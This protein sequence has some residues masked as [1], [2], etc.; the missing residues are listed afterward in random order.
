MMSS[1]EWIRTLEAEAGYSGGELKDVFGSD[2]IYFLGYRTAD[3]E[4]T[5]LH[6][7][8]ESGEVNQVDLEHSSILRSS[9]TSFYAVSDGMYVCPSEELDP[10]FFELENGF[11]S[12]M[13]FYEESIN[14]LKDYRSGDIEP[15]KKFDQLMLGGEILD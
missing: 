8:K 1:E 3:E 2:G 6:L 13:D 10:A 14:I 15:D 4:S 7:E 11:D 5:L 12:D 9:A